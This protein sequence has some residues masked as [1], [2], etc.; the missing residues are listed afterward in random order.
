MNTFLENLHAEIADDQRERRDRKN[1]KARE[2]RAR[3]R[4]E[5]YRNAQIVSALRRLVSLLAEDK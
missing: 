2:T 3:Q 1:A 4:G 5:A